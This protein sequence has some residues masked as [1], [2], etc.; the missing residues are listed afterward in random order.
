MDGSLQMA[1][2]RFV[3][4]LGMRVR[5]GTN[6]ASQVMLAHPDVE[7][8]LP[9]GSTAEFGLLIQ[10]ERLQE[11]Y[12]SI[13][14]PFG[15]IDLT[16]SDFLR[17]AG[18]MV[19]SALLD[20]RDVEGRVV[21][22]KYPSVKDIDAFFSTFPDDRLVIWVRD[23]RDHVASVVKAASAPRRHHT[24]AVR[25]KVSLKTWSRYTMARAAERWAEASRKIRAFLEGLEGHEY[26][27][28]ILVLRYEDMVSDPRTWSA[29]LFDFCGLRVDEEI[30][31]RVEGLPVVGSSFYGRDQAETAVKPTW[32]PVSRTSNFQPVG[33]WQSWNRAEKALFKRVAGPELISWG[34][35]EDDKW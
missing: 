27:D 2:T 10:L 24:S 22:S 32:Q 20:E 34:Y 31:D 13:R 7:S 28:R 3:T 6:Y 11:V 29:Q 18:S 35:V 30:L 12:R 8:L 25:A 15:D 33:R 19:R 17:E 4:L 1:D 14:G 16:E 26:A 9:H 21:F 5:T 23:G